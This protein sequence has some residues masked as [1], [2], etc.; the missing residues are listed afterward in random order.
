MVEPL[1]LGDLVC[2]VSET[3]GDGTLG[4]VHS[5]AP[6]RIL[7]LKEC[8]HR[9][10]RQKRDAKDNAKP[11]KARRLLWKAVSSSVE[12]LM[13]E[14]RAAGFDLPAG[15][16][17]VGISTG[18]VRKDGVDWTKFQLPDGREIGIASTHAMRTV[19]RDRRQE[20]GRLLSRDRSEKSPAQGST[21]FQ[22]GL[23][24]RRRG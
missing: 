17:L 23:R 24:D 20:R 3:P 11:I 19:V 12:Q 2:V 21:E 5:S 9:R 22:A 14:Q 6:C 13:A 10:Y 15:V 1:G 8:Q 16:M 4:Q 18:V 7:P